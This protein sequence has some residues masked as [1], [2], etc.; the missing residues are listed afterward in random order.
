MVPKTQIASIIAEEERRHSSAANGADIQAMRAP[1]LELSARLGWLPG[2]PTSET[3][4]IRCQKLAADFA[5]VFKRVESAFAQTP[6]SSPQWESLLWLRDNAQQLS[7]TARSVSDELG[8]LSQIPHVV[9]GNDEILPRVLA[10]AEAFLEEADT[11]FSDATFTAFC[12]A[13][14]ETAPL[15]YRE[16]G[17]LVPAL[18]LVLLEG[19]A[20]QGLRLVSE[21][22]SA[23]ISK[24]AK[25]VTRY[26]QTLRDVTQA[27]WK[28]ILELL[29]PFDKTLRKD[30]AGAFAVMDIESRNVY[31]ER[32]SR[33]AQRSD[34]S[35]KWQSRRSPSRARPTQETQPIRA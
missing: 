34:R 31:R 18:K 15:E 9:S 24:S 10:I 13:F 23:P 27:S 6:D 29:I 19:I 14:E 5:V 8:S 4:L 20:A 35:W 26:I 7:S 21:P 33:I 32:V 12:L 30:P 17:T 2:T 11:T 22:A 16:I 28:D 1:A 25:P 3:F